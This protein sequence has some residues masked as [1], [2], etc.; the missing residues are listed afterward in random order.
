MHRIC[1]EW[2]RIRSSSLARNASWMFLG[3]AVSFGVQAAYFVLLARLLGLVQYG[4]YAGA[5]ALVSIVSQYS[6]FGSGLLF[7]RYVVPD[8]T[9]FAVY[10]G[11]ILA[12]TASFGT[13]LI[14]AIRVFGGNLAGARAAPL[15]IFVAIS[16]CWCGQLASSCGVIFQAFE[17]MRMTAL[18][19]SL[20]SVLRLVAVYVLYFGLHH[21]SALSWAIAQMCVSLVAV[22]ISVGAVLR[23]YGFPKWEAGL[24]RGHIAEAASWAVSGSTNSA[25]ND[26]DKTMLS[27]YGMNAANGVYTMAYR[28][29]DLATSPIR[30]I[31]AANLPR[32]FREGPEGT[33][34]TRE[35]AKHILKRT[36]PFGI[37]VAVGMFVI[38]PILPLLVGRQYIE[39]SSALRW[40]CLIPLFRCFHL[41]A[42]E[43]LA[44]AGFQNYRLGTQFSIA[45]ANFGLNL[46][47]IPIYGWHGAAWTSL[48]SDALLGVATWSI[49]GLL[50]RRKQLV[51]LVTSP[52]GSAHEEV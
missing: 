1:N 38:A 13:A 46:W 39:S 32:F 22:V 51:E 16:D 17:K 40:L 26:I 11:I 41:S 4:I 20:T 5:V 12:S 2:L 10:W 49:V 36:V 33:N 52:L 18:V 23:L 37:A 34:A 3:Q 6:S 24:F 35:V 9:K 19:V 48:F 14:V 15:L 43:A 28:I 44:G 27:H 8:H 47:L 45:A 29:I 21:V 42:G 50:C 30:A 7:F 31:H 25:F